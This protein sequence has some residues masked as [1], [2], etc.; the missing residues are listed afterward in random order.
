MDPINNSFQNQTPAPAPAPA[1]SP[2]PIVQ[3]KSSKKIG[4][5]IAIFVILVVIIAA[6]LY[7]VGANF[8]KQA[9]PSNDNSSVATQQADVSQAVSSVQPITNTSDDVQSLQN[10]LN[11]STTGVDSQNF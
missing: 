9:P 10:D 3:Q 2:M 6:I 1:P 5:I 8:N 11:N 4:P 7:F